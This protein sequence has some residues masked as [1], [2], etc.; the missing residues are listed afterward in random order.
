MLIYSNF[1]VPQIARTITAEFSDIAGSG[2]F[3]STPYQETSCVYN[4]CIRDHYHVP[5]NAKE[6]LLPLIIQMCH[7]FTQPYYTFIYSSIK[8]LCTA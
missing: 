2:P 8:Q 5:C 4:G 6:T 3:E 1:T 7:P